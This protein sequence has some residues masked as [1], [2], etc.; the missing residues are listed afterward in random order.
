M[1]SW[2]SKLTTTL[3]SNWLLSSHRSGSRFGMSL[4]TCVS[5][6]AAPLLLAATDLKSSPGS[7]NSSPLQ[8]QPARVWKEPLSTTIGTGDGCKHSGLTS[9]TGSGKHLASWNVNILHGELSADVIFKWVSLQKKSGTF[10]L[11]FN[12]PLFSFCF[13]R[14][15]DGTQ[16]A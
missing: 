10:C 15:Y 16:A 1:S 12:V 14:K 3:R 2:I 7:A 8:A 6:R 13:R 11:C 9:N 5:L 4:P